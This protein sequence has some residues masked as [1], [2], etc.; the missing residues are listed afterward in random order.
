MLRGS[1]QLVG[2]HVGGIQSCFFFLLTIFKLW[3]L[4]YLIHLQHI[5]NVRICWYTCCIGHSPRERK[6][7]RKVLKWYKGIE[8]GII[9]INWGLKNRKNIF[10]LCSQPVCFLCCSIQRPDYYFCLERIINDWPLC[11]AMYTFNLHRKPSTLF[12]FSASKTS[13]SRVPV[14]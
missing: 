5:L 12:I 14:A 13:E 7:L 8:D 1:L 6:K 10:C 11:I 4:V 3:I 2:T 9:I